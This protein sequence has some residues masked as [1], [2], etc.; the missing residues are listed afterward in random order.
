MTQVVA[1][2]AGDLD[3]ADEAEEEVYR[4]EHNV[5]RLDDQAPASPDQAC[6][7]QGDVLC[8]GELFSGAVE[9]GDAGEDECPLH[10]WR[11]EMHSLD[12]NRTIPQPLGPTLLSRRRSSTLPSL[13]LE[14]T[15]CRSESL[16]LGSGLGGEELGAERWPGGAEEGAWGGHCGLTPL[17]AEKSV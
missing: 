13:P 9:I 17:L 15:S 4:C 8:E 7:G 3:G 2:D 16:G 11:P 12:P 5:S 10:D 14:S 1:D 6:A